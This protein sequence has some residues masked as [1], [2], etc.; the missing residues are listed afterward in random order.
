MTTR[1]W[2]KWYPSDWRSDPRLRMCSLAARGLW[3]EMICLMH[4]AEPYGSLLVNGAPITDK[5]LASLVG[6]SHREVTAALAELEAAGVFSLDG[7]VIYS[8]RMRRD[9]E[10]S[11]RDKAN[12]K[13][14][15]NP[16]L[17]AGVNPPDKAQKLEARDQNSEPNGSGGK[18]PSDPK[19]EY[20]RRGREVLGPSSGGQLSKLLKSQGKED[21]PR[22]IAK[23]RAR[24]EDASTKAN[25]AE[26]IGRIVVGA[27]ESEN[28]FRDNPTGGS[29]I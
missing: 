26:W 21:D 24:I 20:F 5:Q 19:A 8:R 4:E 16:R 3:A 18:P 9:K 22:T 13:G 25:P 7:A 2:M 1:P 23:A 15:G 11:E 17:K 27:A 12:G 29:L 6:A 28:S 14:G 10:K